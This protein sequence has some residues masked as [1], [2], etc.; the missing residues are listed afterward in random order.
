[1]E[2]DPEGGGTS[3]PACAKCGPK[4]PVARTTGLSIKLVTAGVRFVCP[5]FGFRLFY[6]KFPSCFCAEKA[7]LCS[8]FSYSTPP[9]P[10]HARANPSA[11][12]FC[13]ALAKTSEKHT[14]TCLNT[15]RKHNTLRTW[16]WHLGA[17]WPHARK[18]VRR[19][20]LSCGTTLKT[21][22]FFFKSGATGTCEMRVLT[23][24][25]SVFLDAP[26]QATHWH[27]NRSNIVL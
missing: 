13:W 2:A 18:Q 21:S 11:P 24:H 16:H 4:G 3:G 26:Q 20:H 10:P 17:H 1:M 22:T 25:N 5:N 23:A 19:S 7:N 8:S 6:A 27:I 15:Q 14:K 9:H 12:Q